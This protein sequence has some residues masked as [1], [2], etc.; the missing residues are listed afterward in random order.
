MKKIDDYSIRLEM[1]EI[2]N[3]YMRNLKLSLKNK[4]Y[5]EISW[6]CYSNFEQRVNRSIE[7]NI[8][9]CKK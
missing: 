7:K 9:Y 4:N 8:Q 6:I 1:G 3:K 5:I 2:H